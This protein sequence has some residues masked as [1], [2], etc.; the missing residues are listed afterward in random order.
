MEANIYISQSV[1]DFL[2]LFQS[3]K[4]LSSSQLNNS[5]NLS[6]SIT[7]HTISS[8][9]KNDHGQRDTQEKLR[10]L[11]VDRD[12]NYVTPVDNT[13]GRPPFVVRHVRL[14]IRIFICKNDRVL[15]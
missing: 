12:I 9:V 6:R 7:S 15:G 4:Y 2:Y 14:I 13:R 8:A 3:L 10:E 5:A 1:I 11:A